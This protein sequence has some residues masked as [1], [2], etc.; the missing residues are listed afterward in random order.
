[1]R[2]ITPIQLQ[3]DRLEHQVRRMERVT[4]A[5]R[6]RAVYRQAR[7]GTTPQ[8]LRQAIFGFERELGAARRQL[9]EL[10]RRAGA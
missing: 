3:R 9:A 1:M 7:T 8:P 2:A 6:D 10:R 4:E 5:L